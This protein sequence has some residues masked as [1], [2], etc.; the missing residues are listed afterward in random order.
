MAYRMTLVG[1]TMKIV[2]ALATPFTTRQCLDQIT[3][4]REVYGITEGPELDALWAR[5]DF[6]ADCPEHYN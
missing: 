3:E 1:N 6:L 5:Y 2:P 4:L